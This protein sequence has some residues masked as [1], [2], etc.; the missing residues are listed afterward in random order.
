LES[1]SRRRETATTVDSRTNTDDTRV[2][3]TRDTVVE[4]DVQL[5]DS[6]FLID[7]GFLEITDSS[8]FN[9]VTDGESL[10]GLILGNTT[11]TVET[12][13]ILVVATAVLVTSVISSFTG[14]HFE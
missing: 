4:L 12:T 11:E 8:S 5:G 14:L 10:D 3:S 2:N 6:I 13:N 7:G 1:E 9:H